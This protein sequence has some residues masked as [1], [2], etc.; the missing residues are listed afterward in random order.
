M[1]NMA[2]PRFDSVQCI[3][4][5]GIHRMAYVEWGDAANRD[6]V[7][8]VHGLTRCAR[9]FDRMAQALLPRFR[10]VCPDVVGRG[11]S[12][13][14]K[15]PLLYGIPQYVSDMF[16]L[17]ARVNAQRLMWMGTSMGGLIGMGIAAQKDSPIERMLINDIGPKIETSSLQ[18]IGSY[19]GKMPRFADFEAAVDYVAMVSASFGEHSR[20]EWRE[21][22]R[23]VVQQ[24]DVGQKNSGWTARYDPAIAVPFMSATPEQAAAGEALLWQG[25]SAIKAQTLVARGENSDLLSR[26]T[27]AQMLA[28]NPR[29]RSVEIAGVGHAP[30]FMH[31][32]QIALAKKFFEDE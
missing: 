4:A 11:L 8:C 21:L 9:D 20:D 18:R 27:V 19:L 7:V 29:A 23:H 31:D 10:V 22:T 3:S 13:H 14:L 30:T 26:Q 32:D 12:D 15:N 16:T 24:T 6:V 5:A 28:H 17:L 2:Q 1:A 25:W